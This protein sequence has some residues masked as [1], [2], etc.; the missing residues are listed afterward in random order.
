MGAGQC[1]STSAGGAASASILGARVATGFT[2]SVNVGCE[3]MALMV[4]EYHEARNRMAQIMNCTCRSVSNS[5]FNQLNNQIEVRNSDVEVAG[6][7]R[8]VQKS[9]IKLL[10]QSSIT[11]NVVNEL[12]SVA[13]TM[14]DNTID[15]VQKAAN[16]VG[17]PQSTQRVISDIRTNV[18]SDSYMSTINNSVTEL[19]NNI[20]SEANLKIVIIGSRIR[21]KEFIVEQDT[22]I[23]L[24]AT[25]I[26]NS[27]L[28]NLM[29]TEEITDVINTITSEQEQKNSG[30]S[31]IVASTSGDSPL[32]IIGTIVLVALVFMILAGR[33][34]MTPPKDA[35]G[36]VQPWYASKSL[37][38]L[39]FLC[40]VGFMV[41]G[42][43]I[44]IRYSKKKLEGE[45]AK[46]YAL[47]RKILR[48]ALI[49]CFSLGGVSTLL[50]FVQ[51]WL[52]SKRK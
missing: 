37:I 42:V 12:S 4:N 23:E 48:I 45:D 43:Y 30:L 16:D 15:I 17:A 11:D 33:S 25:N 9:T 28:E 38:V 44:T 7:I 6:A 13:K 24:T 2:A 29:Q 40:G 47:K 8:V 3:Q 51:A 22:L 36:Q 31:T 19:V 41:A 49:V 26:L 46:S 52:M 21:S 1:K 10:T 39:A 5:I 20:S 34:A 35:L 32:V 50:F 27:V 18:N 14:V